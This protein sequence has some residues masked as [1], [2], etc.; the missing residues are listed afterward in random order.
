MTTLTLRVPSTIDDA[1]D[2]LNAIGYA[3]D[4]QRA[5][6]VATF[7]QVEPTRGGDRR[8][9][10]KL[11]SEFETTETFALRGIV[12]LRSA[13]TVRVYA[14]AWLDRFPRPKPGA[15]VPIPDEPWPPT[16]EHDAR[17]QWTP[18]REAIEAQAREDGT[19]ASKA[20]DIAKN[21]KAMAAAIKAS[22]RVAE[23]AR[24]ALRDRVHPAGTTPDKPAPAPG[25][26]VRETPAHRLRSAIETLD[27]ATNQVELALRPFHGDVPDELRD[28]LARVVDRVGL[29][30]DIA[31]GF[32]G[33]TW[34][35][36]Q[37]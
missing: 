19:G 31:R 35:E 36:A 21:T 8:S 13:Q 29:V 37:R 1:A 20:V 32:E 17:H 34:E 27:V 28:R 24:E 5:A 33:V 22:P 11:N 25:G 3:T 9:G 2:H 10:I 4:W 12:G 16:T 26:D 15:L 7:V 6:I 18:D 14:L 30:L 23:A